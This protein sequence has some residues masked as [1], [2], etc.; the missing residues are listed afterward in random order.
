MK[1]VDDDNDDDE[2]SL[3]SKLSRRRYASV[4]N[5]TNSVI[6]HWLKGGDAM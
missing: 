4:S 3:Q 6:W 2:Q 5:Q 1:F